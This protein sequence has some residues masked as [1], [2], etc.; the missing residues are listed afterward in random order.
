MENLNVLAGYALQLILIC[1]VIFALANAFRTFLASVGW[2]N[3][4]HASVGWHSV[5]WVK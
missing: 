4:P 5:G 1:I 2:H 3:K